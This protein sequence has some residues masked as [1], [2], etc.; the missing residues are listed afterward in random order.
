MEGL[1]LWTRVATNPLLE[2]VP[3]RIGASQI[4]IK[5]K[6]RDVVPLFITKALIICFSI[7]NLY[8]KSIK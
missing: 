5:E 2:G 8:R 6:I 3:G 1:Q 4:T 7:N